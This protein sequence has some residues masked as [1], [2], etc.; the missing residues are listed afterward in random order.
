MFQ[1]KSLGD[2]MTEVLNAKY[3]C[4]SLFFEKAGEKGHITQSKFADDHQWIRT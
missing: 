2:R 3:Y 4:T 1:H